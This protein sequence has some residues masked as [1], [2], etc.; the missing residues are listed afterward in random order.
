MNKKI[1]LLLI[2]RIQR[3]K[4]VYFV[5]VKEKTSI[6]WNLINL[7]NIFYWVNFFPNDEIWLFFCLFE[8]VSADIWK[9]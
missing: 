1:L 4:N 9:N 2:Y 7:V 6:L 3:E 8:I 5:G